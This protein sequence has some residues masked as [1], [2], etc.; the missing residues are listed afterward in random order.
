MAQIVVRTKAKDESGSPYVDRHR[1]GRGDVIEVLPDSHVFSAREA[2]HSD[3]RIVQ[4]PGV[5][6]AKLSAMVARDVGYGD[7]NAEKADRV[8]RRRAF[9]LDLAA[10]KALT[11]NPTTLV[12]LLTQPAKAEAYALGLI[13]AAPVLD[14]PAVI[15]GKVDN[16]VLG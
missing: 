12:E 3:W 2:S 15:G 9:R 14:D 7:K 16:K 4:V 11:D 1:Y 8:L 5:S 10:L 13:K 6:P